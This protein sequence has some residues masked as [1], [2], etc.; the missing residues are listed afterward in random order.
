VHTVWVETP[1]RVAVRVRPGA[2]HTRVGGGYDGR[3][4]QALLVSV[5]APPTDGRATAAASK[6]L[7]EAFGVPVR[8]VSLVSGARSRDKIFEVAGPGVPVRLAELLA[9]L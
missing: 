9:D 3:F 6:A 4:G 5:T 8:L 1:T 2:R 7:A